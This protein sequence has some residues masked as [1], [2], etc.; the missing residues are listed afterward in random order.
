MA[1]LKPEQKL[2][3]SQEL[4]REG[5]YYQLRGLGG[6]RN[7]FPVLE[8]SARSQNVRF[9]GKVISSMEL[10]PLREAMEALQ[11]AMMRAV[12][13]HQLLGGQTL[14]LNQHLVCHGREGLGTPVVSGLDARYLEQAFVRFPQSPW[15]NA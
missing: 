2:A 3:L 5:A 14:F 6:E 10:S 1:L 8:Y 4:L 9:T 12:C 11:M 13:R 15:E 7:P